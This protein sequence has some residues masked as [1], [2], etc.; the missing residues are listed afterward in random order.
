[1]RTVLEAVEEGL[2]LDELYGHVLVPFLAW[3]G[4]EWQAGRARVWEEHL[5]TGAVRTAVDALYPRVMAA[6]GQL[7]PLP[8]SVAF[9]CPG[10]ETHDVG[11]R[12]L[13][14]RFDLRGFQTVYVGA[15]TPFEEMI[16]CVRTLEVDVVCLSAST[17]FQRTVLHHGVVRLREA[18]P[19]V[20]IVVGGPAFTRSAEGWEDLRVDSIDGL[21]DDLAK[22]ALVEADGAGETGGPPA[23]SDS[24]GGA[25]A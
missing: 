17:H 16:D 19:A 6:K 25:H 12:M 7:E 5:L 21:L 2:P 1:M 18:L 24:D 14:D 22:G 15:M 13:A 11:L 9:F 23:G 4:S 10:E 8:V 3:L 20:R